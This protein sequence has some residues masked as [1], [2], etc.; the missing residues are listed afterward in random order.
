[1]HGTTEI[2]PDD[3]AVRGGDHEGNDGAEHIGSGAR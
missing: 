3:W 1:M 2:D